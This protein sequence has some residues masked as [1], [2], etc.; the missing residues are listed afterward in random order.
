MALDKH[1]ANNYH[2]FI[3]NDIDRYISLTSSQRVQ[4]ICKPLF[5]CFP[6][7]FFDHSRNYYDASH[8]YLS[9]NPELTQIMFKEGHYRD[10]S[11]KRSNLDR[12]RKCGFYFFNALGVILFFFLASRFCCK[13]F[14]DNAI[15]LTSH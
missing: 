9:T 13:F 3:P 12:K 15:I 2:T 14:C 1:R 6:V 10:K 8:I 4:E 11:T 7:S 5:D